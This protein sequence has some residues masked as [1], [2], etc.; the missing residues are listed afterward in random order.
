MTKSRLVLVLHLF[1][2][3]R[4]WREFS[5]PITES[6]KAKPMQSWIALDTQLKTSLLFLAYVELVSSLS[7]VA[8]IIDLASE[9]KKALPLSSLLHVPLMTVDSIPDNNAHNFLMSIRPS[10]HVAMRALFDVM[11]F[12]NFSRVAI[13]Y[14]GTFV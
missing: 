1:H 4:G 12:F 6:S 3:L 2:G 11:D 7:Q 8:A 5:R 13:V 14:D 10:Y 9:D